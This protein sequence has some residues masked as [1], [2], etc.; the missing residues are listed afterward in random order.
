VLI[1]EDNADARESL[2]LLLELAGHE[3]EAVGDAP[4]GLEKVRT[5]RPHVALIDVGLPGIDGYALARSIRDV[6]AGRT[7]RLVALTGYGQA[8]DR[9]RAHEAGFDLHVTKPVEPDRLEDLL[10]GR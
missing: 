3:V 7:M 5:F 10:A 2:R 8:E 9:R 4:D 6:P 1:V